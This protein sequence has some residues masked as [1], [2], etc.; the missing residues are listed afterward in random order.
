MDA[1]PKVKYRSVSQHNSYVRCAWSYKLN[2]IDRVWQRPASWLSQGLGV[3]VAMEEWERSGR[4]LPIEKLVEIYQEEFIRSVDE[5]AEVTP[6]FDYW[7]ASGPYAGA[8]DIERRFGVGEKQ[9]V[10]LVDYCQSRPDEKVWTTPNGDKAIEL[11]FEVELGGVPVVGFLDQIIE[12]PNG[13]MVRDI[14]TGAKPGDIFQLATYSEAVRILFGETVNWG[15]YLMGKTGK[16]TKPIAITDEDRAEVHKGFAWLEEQIQ[17]GIY[18][19]KPN[20]DTCKMCSVA[21]SCEFRI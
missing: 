6:N 16:P 13:L 7:F 12:T 8:V 14:K 17:A 9:L 2:R 3:H 19:P 15:D 5:Q 10:S 11:R 4:E 20:R 21:T 18:E 1:Q